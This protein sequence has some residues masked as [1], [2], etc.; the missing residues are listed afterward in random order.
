[1]G[2]GINK[3]KPVIGRVHEVI[4]NNTNISAQNADSVQDG[5]EN[6]VVRTPAEETNSTE[7]AADNEK[8]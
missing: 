8:N 1:M 3:L 6:N 7:Q 5:V 2:G 4:D